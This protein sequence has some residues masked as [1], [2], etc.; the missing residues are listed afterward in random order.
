MNSNAENQQI[1]I[2]KIRYNLYLFCYT[3]NIVFLYF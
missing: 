3:N 2:A 1:E